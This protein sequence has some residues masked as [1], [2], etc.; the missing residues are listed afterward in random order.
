MQVSEVTKED[1]KQAG[2]II[3]AL[4]AGEWKIGV[5]DAV[6][7]VDGVRWL[8]ALAVLMAKEIAKPEIVPAAPKKETPAPEQADFTVTSYTPGKIGKS[9]K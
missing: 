6:A 3:Q 2:Q 5:K 7:L 1:C 9:K 8:Q 4:Q